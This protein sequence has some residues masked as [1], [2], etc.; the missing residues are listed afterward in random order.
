MNQHELIMLSPYRFPGQY[1]LTLGDDDMACWLNAFTALWHPALLWQAKG[2]PRCDTQY[3]HE[4]PRPD[5][6][7]AL[8]ES[9]PLY[10]PDD[11]RERVKAAGSI[12]FTATPDRGATLANL[13]EA[14]EPAAWD[15]TLRQLP[16][17]ELGP[18]FGI[19]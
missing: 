8:P 1:L 2:P 19:G 4:Q 16:P 15:E 10:L 9:P 11:W 5:C 18:F 17:E 7:Y 3:D 6:V 13:Q 12:V 14:L